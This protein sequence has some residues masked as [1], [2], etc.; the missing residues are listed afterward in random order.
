M[1]FHDPS[2]YTL[3]DILRT[4]F[5]SEKQQRAITQRIGQ[6]ELWFLCTA[7]PLGEIYTP[8][9]FHDPSYYTFRDILR[10]RFKSEKQQRA[11]TQKIGQ[12][13]L[14]FLCTALR[15]D[16]KNIIAKFEVHRTS[17]DRVML[18]TK[19]WTPPDARTPD[20][21]GDPI[22]RPVFDGRIK[23]VYKNI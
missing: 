2:Y 16:E 3:R 1:K 15:N 10:T 20:I 18:R 9:K 22:I 11:I 14:W 21:T 8:M 13:E 7:L 12:V 17:S 5:K 23:S 4:R 6:V 19:K